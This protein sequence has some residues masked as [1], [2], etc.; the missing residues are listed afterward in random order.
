MGQMS[1]IY[2]DSVNYFILI[3]VGVA[4][5]LLVCHMKPWSF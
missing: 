4:Q 1:W 2:S 5:E 3:N